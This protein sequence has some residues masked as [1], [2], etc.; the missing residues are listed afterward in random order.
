[1]AA[2]SEDSRQQQRYFLFRRF[3]KELRAC[4]GIPA[5]EE[6]IIDNKAI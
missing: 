2:C 1:M 5:L 3:Q 6:K 4:R